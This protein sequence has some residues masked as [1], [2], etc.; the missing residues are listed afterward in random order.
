[1]TDNAGALS[2]ATQAA[3]ENELQA[4]E[5]ATGHQVIVWTSQT[6][7]GVP[8]ETW[9][10]ETAD[11][12]KVGRHGKDDGAVLFLFMQDHKVR[13]EVGYGL[14]SALTDADAHRI[15][16][17]DIVPRMKAGDADG[18]VSSGVA[19]MLTTITPSYTAVTPPPAPSSSRAGDKIATFIVAIS[20]LWGLFFVFIVIMR[21]VRAMRYGYLIMREGSP[22][23]KK[24]MRSWPIWARRIRGRFVVRGR[25]WLWRRWRRLLGGRR[26]LWWRRCVGRLVIHA[27]LLAASVLSYD[28][29]ISAGHEG[30]PASC[31]HFPQHH[32]NLGAD[33]ERAWTPIVADAATEILRAHGVTVAR[34]PADFPGNYRVLAAIFIHFDGSDPPCHSAASIGYGDKSDARAATLWSEALRGVLAVRIRAGQL[35][36]GFARLLRVQTSAGARRESRDRAWRNHVS[37]SARVAG[38]TTALDRRVDCQF[39]EPTRR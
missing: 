28:V 5:K 22:R 18:A 7:G 13:I 34:L 23:A 10:G 11:R 25:W 20:V 8:L 1:M 17:D 32:C 38:V 24:D 29:L 6:T 33:G 14:E 19:A 36:G 37:R 2:S 31:A 12:W 35:H 39:R 26:G 21:I 15:I 30:R 27:L 9:T 4:Y 16:A 3:I